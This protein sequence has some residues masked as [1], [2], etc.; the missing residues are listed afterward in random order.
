MSEPPAHSLFA[1][2]F[3]GGIPLLM[4]SAA[5][6]FTSGVSVRC[7][8]NAAGHAA[9]TEARRILRLF[10]VPIRRHADVTGATSEPRQA[11]DEDGDPYTTHV[12]VLTTP[13]G[14]E[15]LAPFGAQAG[16]QGLVEAVDAYARQPSAAGLE[17]GGQTSLGGTFFHFFS[18]IFI[19]SGLTTFYQYLTGR[20]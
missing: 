17:L 10:D 19:L 6:F 15:E 20:R 14:I 1:T 13:A 4:G 9:C 3:L 5:F 18:T 11:Y 12:P 8:P 2:L 16:V 7:E